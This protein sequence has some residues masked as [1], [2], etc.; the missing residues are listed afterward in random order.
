MTD[1]ASNGSPSPKV[2]GPE[3]VERVTDILVGAF[4]DDPLWGWAFPDP[5][6]RPDQHRALWRLCVQGAVRYPWVWLDAG[7][8]AASVWIPPGGTDFSDEQ[9]ARLEPLLVDLLGADAGRALE[10]FEL[11]DAAHPHDRPHY[12]LSLLGTDPGHRG[13]GYGFGLLADN[14]R[15]IDRESMPAYLEASNSANV[16]LYQRYG[17]EVLSSIPVPGGPEVFTMWREARVDGS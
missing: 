16:P 11:L 15:R 7:Q 14:L 8:M 12:F 4:F 13:H 10:A 6:R 9:A 2:V 1:L 3:Q 5:V 17:F